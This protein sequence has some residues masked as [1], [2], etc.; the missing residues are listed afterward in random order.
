[1]CVWG[2]GGGALT[3]AVYE[4]CVCGG[5]GGAL[6]GAVYEVGGGSFKWSCV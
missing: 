6:T 2:G 5:G 1:M 4:V 3:G